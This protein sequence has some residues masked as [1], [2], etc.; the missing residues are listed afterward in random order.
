MSS[1]EA[2]L[3]ALSEGVKEALWLRHLIEEIK[4]IQNHPTVVFQDN[5]STIAVAENSVHHQKTKH[6][7]VRLQHIRQHIKSKEI[8]LHYCPTDKMIADVLTKALPAKEHWYL[9]NMMGLISLSEI[10]TVTTTV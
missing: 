2:E 7:D 3:Y 5:T 8:K 9:I 1:T 4:I 6:I 10:K